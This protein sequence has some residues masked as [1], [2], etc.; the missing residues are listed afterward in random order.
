MVSLVDRLVLWN[1]FHANNTLISKKVMSNVFICNFDMQVFLGREDVGCF[2]RK[3][4]G[5]FLEHIKSFMFQLL[6]NLTKKINVD[7]LL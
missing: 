2:H 1:E 5:L 3:T 6:P 4:C 7:S